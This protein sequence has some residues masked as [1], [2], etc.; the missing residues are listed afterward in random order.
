M[1]LLYAFASA[2]LL[3]ESCRATDSSHGHHPK[4]ERK[5]IVPGKVFDRF[6]TVWLENTDIDDALNDRMFTLSTV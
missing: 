5:H 2:L 1:F 6:V 4:K 3:L